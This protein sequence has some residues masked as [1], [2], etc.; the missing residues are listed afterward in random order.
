MDHEYNSTDDG[1]FPSQLVSDMPLAIHGMPQKL[2]TFEH[3]DKLLSVKENILKLENSFHELAYRLLGELREK[4]IHVNNIVDCLTV[5][6]WSKNKEVYNLVHEK[7]DEMENEKTLRRL[8]NL[9]NTV[10]NFLDYHLLEYIIIKF[11]SKSLKENMRQYVSDFENFQQNTTLYHFTQCWP[12]RQKKPPE[13]VKV[14]AELRLDPKTCTLHKL[15]ELRRTIQREFFPSLS[16][17]I[18]TLL[19]DKHEMGSFVITWILPP[20]LADQLIRGAIRPE[21]HHFFKENNILSFSVRNQLL[22]NEKRLHV[23]G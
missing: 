7:M 18:S 10:W 11:G 19:D 6:Q 17:Y 9:L 23:Q 16:K 4:N 3:S 2:D 12:G 14:T 1:S 15:D 5:T 8:I 13:Y 21:N 22:Y 20:Q